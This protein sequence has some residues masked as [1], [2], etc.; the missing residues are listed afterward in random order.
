M[1]PMKGLRCLV[2][3]AIVASLAACGGAHQRTGAT[4]TASAPAEARTTA[5]L[6]LVLPASAGGPTTCTVYEAGY[7]TQVVFDSESLDVSPEC[8]AWS[9]RQ[10]GAGYLWDYQPPGAAIATTAVP[11]CDLKDPSGRVSATVVEDTGWAP[12]SAAERQAITSA[13]ASLVAAGWLRRAQLS[14]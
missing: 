8:Q 11:I 5:T 9:S 14:R 3:L 2:G 4:P 10:P 13:C 1:S 7:A 12:V 6:A